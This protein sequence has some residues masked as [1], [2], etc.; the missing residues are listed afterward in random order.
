LEITIPFHKELLISVGQVKTAATLQI[1]LT[2]I[3]TA[4]FTVGM[5]W[6]LQGGAIALVISGV[7]SMLV[8][9]FT[10]RRSLDVSLRA[11][12]PTAL[13]SLAVALLTNVIVLATVLWLRHSGVQSNAVLLAASAAVALG[14]WAGSMAVVKHP[15]WAV[16][17]PH[18]SKLLF[19]RALS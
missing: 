16:L 14:A 15:L 7:I 3:K 11:N 13:R 10:F 19:R 2:L 12:A 5:V 6:G 4:C 9:A 8:V 18:L 17:A 1:R